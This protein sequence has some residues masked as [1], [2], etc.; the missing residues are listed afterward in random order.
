MTDYQKLKLIIL[1][2]HIIAVV[3][4]IYFF[5]WPGIFISLL[6]WQLYYSFGMILGFHR[7][8]AHK[9]F[10]VSDTTKKLML[11]AGSLSGMGSSI[12][13]VGQHRWH[14]AFA[15]QP[16]RDPY[17]SK[18]TFWEKTKAWFLYPANIHFKIS[19]VKDLIGDS[20]HLFFHKNYYKILACWVLLLI[21]ISPYAL[22]YLWAIPAVLTY[23]ALTI[24][25]VLGHNVGTQP[26]SK[27]EQGRDSDILSFFTLGESYQN[28][29]HVNPAAPIQG[30][31]DFIGY[32]SR[33][34]FKK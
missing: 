2:Q 17:Y 31:L 27:T 30:R 19:V 21:G 24:V 13:W 9:T 5:S 11:A 22:I 8:F 7:I 1:G 32:V 4:L 18:F 3:G 25:G 26:H 20:D 10:T 23:T 34:F 16:E 14:H 6:I 29:H 33:I 15:D 12:G 28:M